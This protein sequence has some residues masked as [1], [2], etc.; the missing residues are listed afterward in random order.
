MSDLIE[1]LRRINGGPDASASRVDARIRKEA[2]DRLEANTDRIAELEGM[3]ERAIRTADN[4][5]DTALTAIKKEAELAR[6]LAEAKEREAKDYAELADRFEKVHVQNVLSASRVAELEREKADLVAA[7]KGLADEFVKV[8]AIYY[9][10]EPWAHNRNAHL[11][12]AQALIAKNAE[13]P[14]TGAAKGGEQ[15]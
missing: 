13:T 5:N 15:K 6:Q 9:Y 2:A 12:L 4:A 14:A 10:S 1:R 11:K 8:F 3:L 7:L